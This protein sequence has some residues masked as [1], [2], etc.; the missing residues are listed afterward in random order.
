MYCNVNL[1]RY[2]YQRNFMW[3]WFAPFS[4]LLWTFWPMHV[5]YAMA[6]ENEQLHY[7]RINCLHQ[8]NPEVPNTRQS[9]EQLRRLCSILGDLDCLAIHNL[10]IIRLKLLVLAIV[11]IHVHV[12]TT[13]TYKDLSFCAQGFFLNCAKLINELA[14]NSSFHVFITQKSHHWYET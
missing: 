11:Y 3:K 13:S 4:Q 12:L 5:H 8:Q 9:W 1:G 2:I 7:T 10:N 14:T 6:V